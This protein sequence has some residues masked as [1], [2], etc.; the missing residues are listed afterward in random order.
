MTDHIVN[1]GSPVKAALDR[2]EFL[3]KEPSLQ[4]DAARPVSDTLTSRGGYVLDLPRHPAVIAY[5]NEC[6]RVAWPEVTDLKVAR[7]LLRDARVNL[8]KTT[9]WRLAHGIEWC[10]DG[11]S[12]ALSVIIE[13]RAA[14]KH[15]HDVV[16]ALTYKRR[17]QDANERATNV[18]RLRRLGLMP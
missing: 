2:A 6:K 5:V 15:W 16:N 4:R 12:V 14:A 10:D 18:N 13:H 9:D 3:E 7:K 8:E 17:V 1:G 11:R